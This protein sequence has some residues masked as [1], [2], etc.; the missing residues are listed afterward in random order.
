M[1]LY[2]FLPA[3]EEA[4]PYTTT[5]PECNE[6]QTWNI[7]FTPRYVSVS[8]KHVLSCFDDGYRVTFPITPA[9]EGS[10][11]PA[12]SGGAVAQHPPRVTS[13]SRRQELMKSTLIKCVIS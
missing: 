5:R 11:I 12:I 1:H 10:E 7:L 8:S 2:N 6:I 4:L 13:N 9:V 3:M